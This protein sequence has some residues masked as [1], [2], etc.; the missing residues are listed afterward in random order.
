M[1]FVNNLSRQHIGFG[2]LLNI[3]RSADPAV[4]GHRLT[5]ETKTEA[6]DSAI[7]HWQKQWTA[8]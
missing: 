4:T 5:R 6:M 1:R 2:N 8:S 3:A 7:V